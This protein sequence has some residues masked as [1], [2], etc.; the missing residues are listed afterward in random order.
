MLILRTLEDVQ[1]TEVDARYN[2]IVLSSRNLEFAPTPS[3]L[4]VQDKMSMLE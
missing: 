3:V 2:D 1:H 4:I